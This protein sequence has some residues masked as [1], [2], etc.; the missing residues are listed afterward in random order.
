MASGCQGA[1]FLLLYLGMYV[2]QFNSL[3]EVDE[4]SQTDWTLRVIGFSSVDSLVAT[5]IVTLF[6][7]LGGLV[8][9]TARQF[10]VAHN[11]AVFRLLG[12]GLPPKLRLSEEKRYHL[13]LSHGHSCFELVPRV[14]AP[15]IQV[16]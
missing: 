1:T 9:L 7:L 8:F 10:S 5:M 6:A 11:A 3:E 12:T 14:G 16:R 13:F 2:H 4:L 15:C